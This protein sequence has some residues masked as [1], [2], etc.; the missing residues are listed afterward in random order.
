MP[1]YNPSNIPFRYNQSTRKSFNRGS[2]LA[3]PM[4]KSHNAGPNNNNDVHGYPMSAAKDNQSSPS[5][6]NFEIID[7]SYEEMPAIPAPSTTDSYAFEK[8][9]KSRENYIYSLPSSDHQPTNEFADNFDTQSP[10]SENDIYLQNLSN[11][12]DFYPERMSDLEPEEFPVNSAQQ[13]DY[14]PKMDNVHGSTAS[15][16]SKVPRPKIMQQARKSSLTTQHTSARSSLAQAKKFS[17]STIDLHSMDDANGSA[18]GKKGP[19]SRNGSPTRN[20]SAYGTNNNHNTNGNKMKRNDATGGGGGGGA[21]EPNHARNNRKITVQIL[22]K[23]PPR[24]KTSLD[25][26]SSSAMSQHSM[27][28]GSS[29]IIGVPGAS[30]AGSQPKHFGGASAF[31]GH[32]GGGG[33]GGISSE[34]NAEISVLTAYHERVYQQLSTRYATIQL[35][36][37][38]TRYDS[39][40]K[41]MA[42]A[43]A[44]EDF[45]Q[46]RT[47]FVVVVF[48]L[49]A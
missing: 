48:F 49:S 24:S 4:L 32:G 34:E 37:N 35:I 42:I 12:L 22:A 29:S 43:M 20:F 30:M 5:S 15:T 16:A 31:N 2:K 25:L 1:Y 11:D 44:M 6:I 45:T 13:P 27:A 41:V 38:S 9:V 19:H 46:L 21:K 26:R 33:G 17:S 36:R 39:C 28:S 3:L 14:A 23:P 18:A 7:E 8:L 40:L 47:Y 10:T